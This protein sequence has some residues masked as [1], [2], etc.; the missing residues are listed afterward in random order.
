MPCTNAELMISHAGAVL[1]LAPPLASL[2]ND[3]ARLVLA[4]CSFA[5]LSISYKKKISELISRYE[6]IS[7]SGFGKNKGCNFAASKR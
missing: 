1:S 7:L 2:K 3:S 6:K 4:K 5:R